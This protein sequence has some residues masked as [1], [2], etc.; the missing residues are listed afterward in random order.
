MVEWNVYGGMECCS[1]S[2]ICSGFF[3]FIYG[4]YRTAFSKIHV[5]FFFPCILGSKKNK[6][7]KKI[8]AREEKRKKN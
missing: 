1:S 4:K 7:R 5:I 2:S 3:P 8:Q 6:E